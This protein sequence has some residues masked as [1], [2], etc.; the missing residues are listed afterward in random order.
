MDSVEL[1]LGDLHIQCKLSSMF[2]EGK[3]E[4][5]DPRL[6]QWLKYKIFR[7]GRKADPLTFSL[8]QSGVESFAVE[9]MARR[10]VR[11][12]PTA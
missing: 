8:V 9:P 2:W 4:I 12:T 7:E 5:H 6:C 11:V 3:P 10:G 1:Q